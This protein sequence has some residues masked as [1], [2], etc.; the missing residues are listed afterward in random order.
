MIKIVENYAF[1]SHFLA[2]T[3]INHLCVWNMPLQTLTIAARLMLRTL[4]KRSRYVKV[5]AVVQWQFQDDKLKLSCW[6]VGASGNTRARGSCNAMTI[7]NAFQLEFTEN[8]QAARLDARLCEEQGDPRDHDVHL[9]G[10]PSHRW[11]RQWR[12]G[13]KLLLCL[14]QPWKPFTTRLRCCSSLLLLLLMV[15]LLL[16]YPQVIGK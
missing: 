1:T 7:N 15:H 2:D 13:E 3:K 11:Q 4:S 8:L 5:G 10:N 14:L 9:G 16:H 6:L 12:P